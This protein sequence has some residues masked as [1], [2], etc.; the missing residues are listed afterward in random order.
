MQVSQHNGSPHRQLLW[1]LMNCG[2]HTEGLIPYDPSRSGRIA[3]LDIWSSI[4]KD[5][6]QSFAS[7]PNLP[8]IRLDELPSRGTCL[9]QKRRM[10]HFWKCKLKQIISEGF[11][12]NVLEKGV[13]NSSSISPK[14]RQFFH[15]WRFLKTAGFQS[16]MIIQKIQ[17]KYLSSPH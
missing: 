5:G 13:I 1:S 6:R 7:L 15:A 12:G 10:T 9:S 8:I 14:A 2:N 16:H 11:W 3:E 4:D 17:K